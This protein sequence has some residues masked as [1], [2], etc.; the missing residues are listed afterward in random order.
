MTARTISAL[1]L[2]TG[3]CGPDADS[4]N[5]E[6]EPSYFAESAAAFEIGEII[7]QAMDLGE[8]AL[9]W[10]DD[11][12]PTEQ[13]YLIVDAG[14]DRLVLFDRNL[15]LLRTT[16]RE[17][18]GP[19]EYQFI[20]RIASA[21]DRVVVLDVGSVSASYVKPDGTFLERSIL[22]PNPTDVAW[23]PELGLVVADNGSPPHYLSRFHDGKQV[24]FAPI[25]TALRT[26]QDGVY[27]VRTNLVAV[28]PD[29]MIHVFDDFHLALVSY[30]PDGTLRGL[31]F[32]PEPTRSD[33]LQRR[34]ETVATFG[35]SSIVLGASTATILQPL[36]DGRLF[37]RV[38]GS[39]EEGIGYVLDSSNSEATPVVFAEGHEGR[40]WGAHAH[41]ENDQILL[42]SIDERYGSQL[43]LARITL[44]ER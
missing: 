27:R 6:P 5:A 3:A 12:E 2:T 23:H 4:R 21:A 29:G 11:V 35:G 44:V 36:A 17:G 43:A 9:A 24:A 18:N 42:Y 8:D 7:A 37:V 1:L 26:D 15:N 19:G 39:G 22:R 34:A 16:G 20:R 14:N 30:A 28:T 31:N 32:L 40:R 33:K 10:A 38:A 13:G 25:P 41:F